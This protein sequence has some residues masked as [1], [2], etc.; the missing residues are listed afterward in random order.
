VRTPRAWLR[1]LLALLTAAAATLALTWVTAPAAQAGC[2]YQGGA[3]QGGVNLGGECN[4]GNDNPGSHDPGNGPWVPTG[5]PPPAYEDY[6]APACDGNGPPT[7]GGGDVMCMRA[8]SACKYMGQEGATYMS[9]WRRQVSPTAGDWTFA[10]NECRGADEATHTPPQVTEEMVLDQAFA[11]APKPTAAV[12]PGDRTYVNIPNNYYADA[13]DQT[14]PVE[15][16]GHTIEV[17]FTV[18]DVT[19]DFG[20]GATGTGAG[21]RDADVGAPGAVEHAYQQ[22]GSYDITVTSRL[23]VTFTLPNGQAVNLPGAFQPSSAPVT[24]P[25]GEIQTRV[26]STG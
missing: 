5:P 22:Q 20:D 12:Q 19:W 21:I 7:Q 13:E 26:D 18:A 11:A 8:A 16:L 15:V 25:V 6:W 17:T 4:G 9:H 1:P 3:G 2:D 10:G 14:V 23:N 24:L